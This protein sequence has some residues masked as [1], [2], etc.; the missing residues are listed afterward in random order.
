M[1]KPVFDLAR[2]LQGGTL[3]QL[4][5]D[6]IDQIL[7][8]WEEYGDGDRRKLAYALATAN[9]ESNFRPIVENLNYTSA[10][11]IAQVWPSRFT[12]ETAKPYVKKAQKLAN[13]VYGGRLGNIDPDDGWDYRGRGYS[14]LTGKENYAKFSKLI[15]VDLLAN[16][17]FA[18]Q[19]QHAAKI[20]IVGLMKGMFTGKK[21][22]DYITTSKADYVNARACVNADIKA[23]GQKI[24]GYAHQF[25]EALILSP[26]PIIIEPAPHL[27]PE[28][29][30]HN[31]PDAP[32]EKP[33]VD[34]WSDPEQEPKKS[35]AG[36]WILTILGL[37]VLAVIAFFTLPIG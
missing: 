37:I 35:H 23:N 12:V 21:L 36:A 11:R 2:A 13:K 32:L 7:A 24:A 17:D 31:P 33:E 30:S 10:A 26:K 8:A 29:S 3:D 16:P 9:H 34:V 14:Q 25:E 18:K 4:Q 22:G 27:G 6:S 5:V 15:G 20:L 28:V 1:M 19:P